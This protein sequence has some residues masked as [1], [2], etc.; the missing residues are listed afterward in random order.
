MTSV[1]Q[2]DLKIDS[3]PARIL[4][5]ETLSIRGG[6]VGGDCDCYGTNADFRRPRSV[7]LGIERGCIV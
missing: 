7:D 4:M 2:C 5:S 1:G 6:S 3:S